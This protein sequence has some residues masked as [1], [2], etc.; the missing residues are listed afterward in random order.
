MSIL[1]VE[2]TL[3]AIVGLAFLPSC[4]QLGENINSAR[5]SGKYKNNVSRWVASQ[6]HWK[7][8]E[9]AGLSPSKDNKHLQSSLINILY[10]VYI[11]SKMHKNYTLWFYEVGVL[12]QKQQI[13]GVNSEVA[14]TS[15]LCFPK[16]R[17]V[18]YIYFFCAQIKETV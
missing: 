7:Q 12:G 2:H 17:N 11:H 15:R 16:S 18:L 9:A 3:Q 13:P 1:H 5:M 6:K 4:R 10:L 14:G 8:R